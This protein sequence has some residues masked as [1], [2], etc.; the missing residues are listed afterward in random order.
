VVKRRSFTRWQASQRLSDVVL[1]E[2]VGELERGL[3]DARLSGELYKKRVARPN[4][5]KRDGFR[6][7]IAARIAHRAVFLEGFAKN[8]IGN[9]KND[10]LLALKHLGRVLLNL[11]PDAFATAIEQGVLQEVEC[12]E[13]DH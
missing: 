11:L 10:E 13:Q 9:I 6:V 1:C 7:F 2:A 12:Y 4:G 3:V 5:G 8:D